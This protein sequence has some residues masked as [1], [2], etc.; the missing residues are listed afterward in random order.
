[1]KADIVGNRDQGQM[2]VLF[3]KQKFLGLLNPVAVDEFREI[4]VE[5]FVDD[6]RQI[7]R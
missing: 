5:L 6:L 1:M 2:F 4:L 7:L 3:I